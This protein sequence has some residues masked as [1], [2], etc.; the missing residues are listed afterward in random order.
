MTLNFRFSLLIKLMNQKQLCVP[1]QGGSAPSTNHFSWG[2]NLYRLQQNSDTSCGIIFSKY[3]R[4]VFSCEI[5]HTIHMSFI[6]I[7][8]DISKPPKVCFTLCYYH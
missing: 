2:K 5:S 4:V 8:D 6:S 3:K 7:L 1:P